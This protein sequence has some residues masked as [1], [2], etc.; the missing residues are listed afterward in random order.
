M[1]ILHETSMAG[2]L[3]V[4]SG[5]A[6]TVAR[7]IVPSGQAASSPRRSRQDWLAEAMQCLCYENL[8]AR[9]AD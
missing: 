7:V 9:H 3:P 5:N 8:S 1:M 2:Q 6:V 4:W